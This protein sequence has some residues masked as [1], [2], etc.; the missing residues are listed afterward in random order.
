MDIQSHI[1]FHFN[2]PVPDLSTLLD[3]VTPRAHVDRAASTESPG[4]VGPTPDRVLYANVY[5]S[6]RQSFALGSKLWESAEEA[7][8]HASDNSNGDVLA[9]S[10][11]GD[12]V[13]VA[14][15]GSQLGDRRFW[16]LISDTELGKDSFT[17]YAKL[18]ERY[19]GAAAYLQ[20]SRDTSGSIS[21]ASA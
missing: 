14:A 2:G 17:E 19:P 20:V 18:H 1:H 9:I 16:A 5:P 15:R 3:E 7:R 21:V 6:S 4:E 12:G 13:R 8:S 11:I 10:I